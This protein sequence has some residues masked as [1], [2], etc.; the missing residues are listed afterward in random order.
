MKGRYINAPL[1][2]LKKS[3]FLQAT[4]DISLKFIV[5][6]KVKV[7]CLGRKYKVTE[8]E[9]LIRHSEDFQR[10][11]FNSIPEGNRDHL[12][13]FHSVLMFFSFMNL[14]S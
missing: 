2:F 14:T 3:I 6:P 8:E 1:Y 9:K 10:N 13:G 12:V 11:F 5:C 7:Q 4:K